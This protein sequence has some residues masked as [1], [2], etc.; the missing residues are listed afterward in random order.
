MARLLGMVL[1]MVRNSWV[2]LRALGLSALLIILPPLGALVVAAYLG[3]WSWYA[4]LVA[5]EIEWLLVTIGV[6]WLAARRAAV[7][8]GIGL[9]AAATEPSIVR[10]L[11]GDAREAVADALRLVAAVLATE[12]VA[13]IIVVV[14]PIHSNIVLSLVGIPIAMT[15][16]CYWVWQGG[17]PWWPKAVWWLNMAALVAVLTGLIMPYAFPDATQEIMSQ[18]GSPDRALAAFFRGQGSLWT[19]LGVLLLLLVL[20]FPL[21]LAV[22]QAHRAAA[23]RAI[24]WLIVFVVS[25]FA[26]GARGDAPDGVA[27]NLPRAPRLMTTPHRGVRTIEVPLQGFD[28]LTPVGHLLIPDLCWALQPGSARIT[29]VKYGGKPEEPYRDTHF[30]DERVVEGLRGKGSAVLL[31]YRPVTVVRDRQTVLSC[32]PREALGG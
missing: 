7:S 18:S 28:R 24:F 22:P 14:A 17:T 13:G 27:S 25:W 23:G 8:G 26:L 12:M 16:V 21:L 6:I 3:G 1:G 10:P 11:A 15:F 9:A 4:K 30:D 32:R 2:E 29:Q 20:R 19:T 31:I 5:I